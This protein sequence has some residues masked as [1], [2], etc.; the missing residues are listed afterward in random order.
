[1]KPLYWTRIIAANESVQPAVVNET[2]KSSKP[3]WLVSI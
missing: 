2:D 3:L 1:M